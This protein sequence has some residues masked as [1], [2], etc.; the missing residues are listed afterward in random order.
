MF[1]VV[2][3]GPWPY[4][5]PRR[6]TDRGPLLPDAMRAE[7]MARWLRGTG[8]YERVDVVRANARVMAAPPAGTAHTPPADAAQ[9]TPASA[10]AAI[11]ASS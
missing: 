8:L 7:R 2:C 1:R 4:A 3:T 10:S 6:V 9:T 11:P 5:R